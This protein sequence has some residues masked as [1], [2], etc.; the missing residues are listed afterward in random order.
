MTILSVL[1]QSPV[2]AG[3][4]PAQAIAETLELAR[5]AD[6]LGYRRYWLAEHH[7]TAGLAGT[8]PEILI[9]RIAAATSQI[10]VGSGGVMLSH[11]SALKVAE[12]FRVLETLYPGRIDLGIGRAPGSDQR[13]AMA[14]QH[15]PGALTIEQ[16]PDQISDL[17]GYLNGPLPADQPFAS[18]KAMPTGP[19]A[20]DLWLLGSS[21]ASA[22]YAA[23]FGCAFSFAHF[24]NDQGGPEVMQAYRESFE[25]SAHLAKPQGSIGV[26]VLCAETEVEADRLASSRDLWRL[27]LDLGII[28]P[29]PSVEEALSHPYSDIERRRIAFNRRRQIIGT[30]EQVKAQLLALGEAYGVDEFVV[31][32]ICYDFAARKRSYEL[33][34][35]AFGL[36]AQAKAEVATSGV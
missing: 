28:G 24:I 21:D 29:I 9:T 15:G 18:I 12:Q 22:T 34:A 5:L 26:F 8:A 11:Y 23:H 4:T 6:K 36:Q 30:P 25:P 7:N 31:V 16:F 3:G 17:I 19:S 32:S 13:T 14:L 20:P 10:R 35:E 2:R 1:D 27:R 33:L